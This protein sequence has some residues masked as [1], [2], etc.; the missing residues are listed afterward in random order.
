MKISYSHIYDVAR[1]PRMFPAEVL[2][3]LDLTMAIAGSLGFR[4]SSADHLVFL[5]ICGVDGMVPRR[6]AWEGIYLSDEVMIRSIYQDELPSTILCSLTK[7]F[8]CLYLISCML[9]PC[10]LYDF[11]VPFSRTLSYMISLV[12]S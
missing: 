12:L 9:S 1:R 3:E 2:R 8:P 4:A 10:L 11:Y 6:I 5:K 7:F